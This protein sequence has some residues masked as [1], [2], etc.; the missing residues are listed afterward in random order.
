MPLK[1][2]S[3]ESLVIILTIGSSVQ[4]PFVCSLCKADHIVISWVVKQHCSAD[5]STFKDLFNS[6]I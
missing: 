2:Q 3:L 1:E 5:M 4:F 6:F